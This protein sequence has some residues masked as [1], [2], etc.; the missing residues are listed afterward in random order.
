VL[1]VPGGGDRRGGSGP[2][3]ERYRATAERIRQELAAL[4]RVIARATRAMGRA[5]EQPADQDLYLDSVALNLQDFYTGIERAFR[6]IAGTIDEEVPAGHNWHEELLRQ[7]GL[8]RTG[9]RPAVISSEALD[10]LDSYLRFRHV[11]RNIYSFE[12]DPDRVGRLVENLSPGFRRLQ[13]E[14]EAFASFLERLAESDE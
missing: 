10:F 11:V 7:M 2:L 9:I 12:F 3:I 4:E 5:R 13:R 14:M 6:Q 8:E 1:A